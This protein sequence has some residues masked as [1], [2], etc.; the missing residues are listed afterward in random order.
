VARALLRYDA[1]PH[2]VGYFVAGWWMH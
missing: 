1:A 2:G